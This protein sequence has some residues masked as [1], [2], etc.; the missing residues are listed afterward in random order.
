MDVRYKR[1]LNNSQGF[2]SD[3]STT[4][5]GYSKTE[6]NYAAAGG[7]PTASATE[8]LAYTV[9]TA[10]TLNLKKV[11]YQQDVGANRV[12][13]LYDGLT[14]ATGT[15]RWQAPDAS[16]TATEYTYDVDLKFSTG[17][18]W[19]WDTAVDTD[20][21]YTISGIKEYTEYNK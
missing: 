11:H 19:N 14:V 10:T 12:V 3:V 6:G 8:Y 13:K 15:L 7:K 17:V 20:F 1:R 2:T 4:R 16:V 18:C 21:S 5:N 9:P